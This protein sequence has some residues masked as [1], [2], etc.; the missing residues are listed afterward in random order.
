MIKACPV[1]GGPLAF[2]EPVWMS[3]R[4]S[5]STS[6][7][8]ASAGRWSVATPVLSVSEGRGAQRRA[9]PPPPPND[10]GLPRK[11]WAFGIL[12]AG[13]DEHPRFGFDQRAA[14][15]RR[16]VE[17][18]DAG[19]ERQRRTRRAAPSIPAASTHLKPGFLPGF[20]LSGWRLVACAPGCRS[21]RTIRW[22]G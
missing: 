14:G 8:Q 19:P 12:G 16:T 18:S 9:F 6:E 7:R 5:G 15:E 13:V 20:Y 17:R 4:V 2:W 11:G 1:R 21:G 3:T 10:K 22:R